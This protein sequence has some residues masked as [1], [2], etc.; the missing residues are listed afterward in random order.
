MIVFW[1]IEKNVNGISKYK[2]KSK[3]EF[4]GLQ[5]KEKGLEDRE[6]DSHT[7]RQHQLPL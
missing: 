1:H 3:S 5:W 2:S 4:G 6:S 7:E